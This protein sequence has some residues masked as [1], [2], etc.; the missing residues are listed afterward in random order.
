MEIKNVVD[1]FNEQFDGWY[2]VMVYWSRPAIGFLIQKENKLKQ[3]SLTNP[4]MTPKSP[5]MVFVGEG[6]LSF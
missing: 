5:C 4:N 6:K 1:S 2:K 3:A